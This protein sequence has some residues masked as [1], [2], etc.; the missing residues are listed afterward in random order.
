MVAQAFGYYGNGSAGKAFT[1]YSQTSEY[2]V[3]QGGSGSHPA[4]AMGYA[5]GASSVAFAATS[6]TSASFE[7]AAGIAVPIQ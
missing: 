5:P 2:A 7:L 3:T 1:G 4:M 6:P